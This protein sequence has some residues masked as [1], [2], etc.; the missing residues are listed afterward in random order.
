MAHTLP[1]PVGEVYCVYIFPPPVG[2]G[3]KRIVLKIGPSLN[4][5]RMSHKGFISL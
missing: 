5:Q 4:R 3:V 1:P 2:V